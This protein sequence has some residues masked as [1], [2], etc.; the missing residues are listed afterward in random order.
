MISE[1]M[2]DGT[3]ID[4][5]TVESV[6]VEQLPQSRGELGG[7]QEYS[8]VGYN[9]FGEEVREDIA[10][11]R[12]D[13]EGIGAFWLNSQVSEVTCRRSTKMWKA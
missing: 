5:N 11:C 6:L 1:T 4:R 7:A 9:A 8:I 10:A 2:L 3:R 13:A 12:E